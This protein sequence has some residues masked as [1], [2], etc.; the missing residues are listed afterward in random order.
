MRLVS[1][2]PTMS[3]GV[4]ASVMGISLVS[5]GVEEK[6]AP[7]GARLCCGKRRWR[8][9]R[10]GRNGGIRAGVGPT[11]LRRVN[12]R[13][14]VPRVRGGFLVPRVARAALGAPSPRAG[15]DRCARVGGAPGEWAARPC[16]TTRRVSVGCGP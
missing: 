3:I 12:A 15:W 13:T 5:H 8:F 11:G 1:D 9:L 4:N 14:R 16:P 6:K 7:A 10:A 2:W